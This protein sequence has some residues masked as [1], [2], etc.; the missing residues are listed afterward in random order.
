MK[1]FLSFLVA[2]LLAASSMPIFAAK[3]NDPLDLHNLKQKIKSLRSEISDM[4]KSIDDLE[5]QNKNFVMDISDFESRF[6]NR[7]SKILVPLLSWPNLSPSFNK[8][9]WIEREEMKAVLL[10]LRSRLIHEPLELISAREL[11]ISGAQ[12]KKVELSGIVKQLESKKDLL[13]LQLEELQF[14]QNKMDQNKLD[15]KISRAKK[16]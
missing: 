6:Q 4:H 13:S 8:G 10:S 14:L 7:F 5:R 16:G 3:S 15:R 9:S 2:V 1:L 11:M 12:N